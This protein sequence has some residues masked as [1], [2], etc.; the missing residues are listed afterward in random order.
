MRESKSAAICDSTNKSR[1][2]RKPKGD[3]AMTA[4]ERKRQQRQRQKSQRSEI[5]SWLQLRRRLWEIVQREFMFA[6]AEELAHGLRAMSL[7]VSLANHYT[8]TGHKWA[9]YARLFN[10]PLSPEVDAVTREVVTKTLEELG[11]YEMPKGDGRQYVETQVV[12]DL[13]RDLF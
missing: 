11:P 1:K 7:M 12:F 2:G 4:A 3:Q 13:F 9:E 8:A 6:N 5:P 10:D